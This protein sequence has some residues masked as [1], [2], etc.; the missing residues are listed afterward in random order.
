MRMW[1]IKLR[2]CASPE[3]GRTVRVTVVPQCTQQ[4]VISSRSSGP[5][6]CSICAGSTDVMAIRCPHSGQGR[7]KLGKH[8]GAK[9]LHCME[10]FP[11][12]CSRFLTGYDIPNGI[13]P[14]GREAHFP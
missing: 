10:L 9:S 4:W 12:H 6:P 5:I 14:R 13:P 1:G 7:M 2:W 11:V 8:D 3:S